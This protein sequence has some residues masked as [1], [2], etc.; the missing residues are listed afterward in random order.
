MT[1]EITAKAEIHADVTLEE[2]KAASL[3]ANR[4]NGALRILPLIV[5]LSAVMLAIG[6]CTVNWYHITP[7]S[8]L[9]SLLICLS[10]PIMLILLFWMIPDSVK[11]KAEKDF[12]TY[13][14]LMEPAVIRLY[15]DDA[16]TQTQYL[17]L[18][19]SYAM[20]NECIETPTLFVL[21]KDSERLLIVPKRCLKTEQAG[22]VTAFL[23]LVFSRKR[24]VMKN[25]IF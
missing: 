11:K 18:T 21:I 9:I 8:L 5:L 2:Y 6:L 7:L 3:I 10:C 4:R 12:V 23:R 20:M 24:R 22:E 25:W 1:T 14:T 19:D 16:V 17:T 15:A 13:Q